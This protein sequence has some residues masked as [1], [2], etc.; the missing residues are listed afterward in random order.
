M[1]GPI[2]SKV[3][4]DSFLLLSFS[5]LLDSPVS[6][7]SFLPSLFTS[8]LLGVRSC[9]IFCYVLC[10]KWRI[11][12]GWIENVI[13]LSYDAKCSCLCIHFSECIQ[14]STQFFEHPLKSFWNSYFLFSLKSNQWDK[15][16]GTEHKAIVCLTST[17]YGHQSVSRL[18]CKS[19]FPLV[20]WEK[21][22]AMRPLH[23]YRT[24]G[25]SSCLLA[26]DQISCSHW[27]HLG[28]ES[29]YEIHSFIFPPLFFP[30][31]L[32]LPLSLLFF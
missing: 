11:F 18:L 16:C 20:S 21:Q 19:S 7:P 12:K 6:L 8:F 27:S 29:V 26:S 31:S 28:N 5:F 24:P 1:P 10:A 30:P 15:C 25:A 3:F 9:F 23:T 14:K 13:K 22:W 32:S 4:L 2:L 17:S